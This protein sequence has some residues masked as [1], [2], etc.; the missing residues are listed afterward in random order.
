MAPAG[1]KVEG[2]VAML[3]VPSAIAVRGETRRQN[4]S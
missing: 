1:S 2:P 3:D 4:D